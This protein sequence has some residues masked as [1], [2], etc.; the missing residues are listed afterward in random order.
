MFTPMSVLM[1]ACIS[2]LMSVLRN[3]CYPIAAHLWLRAH[4]HRAHDHRA[5]ARGDRGYTT[6][7]V[8]GTVA[9]AGLALTALSILGPKIISKMNAID[10]GG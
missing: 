2:G 1:S 7:V 9:L 8:I 3:G 10:L 6:E 4:D 5:R